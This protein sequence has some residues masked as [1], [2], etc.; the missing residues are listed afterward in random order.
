MVGNSTGDSLG[1]PKISAQNLAELGPHKIIETPALSGV[2][3]EAG[4][5]TG[6]PMAA[7][8]SILS[9]SQLS[10]TP[11]NEIITGKNAK[12]EDIKEGPNAIKLALEKMPKGMGQKRSDSMMTIVPN[13]NDIG[14]SR[15]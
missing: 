9:M 6:I 8:S 13:L 10:T 2:L 3:L 12:G 14:F 1:L 7:L 4:P 11:E 5:A 15:T